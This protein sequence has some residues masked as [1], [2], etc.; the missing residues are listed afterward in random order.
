MNYVLVEN[1]QGFPIDLYKF[2]R[3]DLAFNKAWSL[4]KE[5]KELFIFVAY[6][7]SI[8]LK[9]RWISSNTMPVDIKTRW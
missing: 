8:S 5:H 9:Y 3:D 7:S 2:E 6:E 1:S 4:A